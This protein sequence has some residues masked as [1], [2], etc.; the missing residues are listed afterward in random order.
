MSRYAFYNC[1][2]KVNPKDGIFA[3]VVCISSYAGRK[4]RGVA[5]CDAGDEFD[6]E[7]GT[8]LA[9]ARVDLEIAKRRVKRAESKY[10]EAL[11]ACDR[12]DAHLEE[13]TDYVDE[14][15]IA[16]EEAENHLGHLLNT[17]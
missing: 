10:D 16:L 5:I 12:A 7:R 4:V 9:Q 17:F 2:S 11:E 1:P 6:W 15:R 3:K 13:M 14:S 8:A